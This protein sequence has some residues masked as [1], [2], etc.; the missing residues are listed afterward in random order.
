M[1]SGN[2]MA[3]YYFKKGNSWKETP[4]FNDLAGLSEEL[5]HRPETDIVCVRD[6]DNK[7]RVLSERGSAEL[8]FDDKKQINYKLI[9][10]DPF[11]YIKT[12]SKQTSQQVLASSIK[13]EYPD[14]PLQILQLFESPRTGDVVISAKPGFDLRATHENPEHCG[15]HGSLH[16]DHML[17]PI[18]MN[19]NSSSDYARTVDI[20]PTI[21]EHLGLNTLDNLDGNSLLD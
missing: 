13:S 7:V 9:T 8:W 20:F 15:S 4:Y 2:S 10:E 6:V 12:K 11:G 16:R 1:V 5:A 14:A 3:H 18:I 19:K 21:T 17:V